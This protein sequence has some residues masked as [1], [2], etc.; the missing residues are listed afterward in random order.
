V[1]VEEGD[2]IEEILRLKGERNA[3]ILAHNYQMPEI[4]DI[5]D[6]IGDSLDLARK[7]QTTDAD[8]IVFCGVDFM[9]ETTAMINPGKTVLMP[10]RDA[11]CP[12]AAML[13]DDIIRKA[14]EEHPNAEVVMYINTRAAAKVYADC[15]CT[16]SNAVKVVESMGSDK[17]IFAPDR[18]LAHYVQQKTDKE[19]IVV[20]E[21]GMCIVHEN[22]TLKD[23]KNARQEH[24]DA[25]LTVHPEVPPKVQDEADHIGSTNQMIQYVKDTKWGEYIIGTEHGIIHRMQKEA[26]DKKYYPACTRAVCLNMKKT[27]LENLR[28]AL[29]KMQY[30]VEVPKE[31]AEKARAPIQRMLDLK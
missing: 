5:A 14:R 20:P 19:L 1:T 3:V 17:V 23:V 7:A 10:A 24:P 26:P 31:T 12:M 22:I 2:L 9:S 27:N 16:S 11:S 28:D 13:P 25:K 29:D 18:N 4:Q 30:K 6:L 21:K 8:V 15:V